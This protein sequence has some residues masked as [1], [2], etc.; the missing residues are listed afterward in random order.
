[1]AS[2]C[3][4]VSFED[5]L[6]VL[7]FGTA[8][9]V[10]PP[11]KPLRFPQLLRVLALIMCRLGPSC[12]EE[13]CDV[14]GLAR[15]NMDAT[16]ASLGFV[17]E[18]ARARHDDVSAMLYGALERAVRRYTDL[19]AAALATPARIVV[20][21]RDATSTSP[22]AVVAQRPAAP[23]SPSLSSTSSSSSASDSDSDADSDDDDDIVSRCAAATGNTLMR[24]IAR[25]RAPPKISDVRSVMMAT[26]ERPMHYLVDRVASACRNDWA[27]PRRLAY[28][29][30][31]KTDMV[32][33]FTLDAFMLEADDDLRRIA[34]NMSL[35]VLARRC[36][37]HVDVFVEQLGG[38]FLVPRAEALGAIERRLTA[39]GLLQPVVPNDASGFSWQA[40]P[41]V[42]AKVRRSH[43]S[44]RHTAFSVAL[45]E[46]A[47][48]ARH[49][50]DVTGGRVAGG[51]YALA[52][53]FCVL[54]SAAVRAVSG[55]GD[56]LYAK[57]V[58]LMRDA[59]R[60]ASRMRLADRVTNLNATPDAPQQVLVADDDD[61]PDVFDVETI[62]TPRHRLSFPR[63]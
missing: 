9:P 41:L 46:S 18:Q 28:W 62:D 33:L 16:S 45:Q 24:R 2:R 26:R 32:R 19:H 59:F 14:L 49:L 12:C 30:V 27:D 55:A 1:M 50:C 3:P 29:A 35:N 38:R 47:T 15:S 39:V 42:V 4:A 44:T 11:P 13:L 34:H 54:P 31:A 10:R 5:A 52:A 37:P 21:H 61:E 22:T 51:A 6:N 57:T 8:R 23:P 58:W 63:S 25:A 48:R 60:A 40:R 43:S 7:E 53:M 56:A 17:V 36:F 20:R